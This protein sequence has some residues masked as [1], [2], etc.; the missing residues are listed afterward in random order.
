MR[1]KSTFKELMLIIED[2][3]SQAAI[4][5]T[6]NIFHKEQIKFFYKQNVTA[7]GEMDATIR[8]LTKSYVQHDGN[9]NPMMAINDKGPAYAFKD[10]AARDQFQKEYWEFLGKEVYLSL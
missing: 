1:K 7:I 8:I 3:Q 10:D 5:P 2:I 4:H 6:F 9:N